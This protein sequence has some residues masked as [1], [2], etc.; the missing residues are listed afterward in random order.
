MEIILLIYLN[1][2]FYYSSK[3]V[4]NA[5]LYEQD[6]KMIDLFD[7]K[8][9]IKKILE[10][11]NFFNYYEFFC[12]TSQI[13]NTLHESINSFEF[14]FFKKYKYVFVDFKDIQPIYNLFDFN[15]YD[16]N[17]KTKK[18][19]LINHIEYTGRFFRDL[20]YDI[21]LGYENKLFTKSNNINQ[22]DFRFIRKF[23]TYINCKYKIE[24]KKFIDILDYY[25]N[26]YGPE[27]EKCTFISHEIPIKKSNE[28]ESI[29]KYIIV[30]EYTFTVFNHFYNID[31]DGL[32]NRFKYNLLI[33]E[34]PNIRFKE[35][36]SIEN[37]FENS[38]VIEDK[39]DEKLFISNLNN[40]PIKLNKITFFKHSNIL[41]ISHKKNGKIQ[42][43]LL[44]K[45]FYKEKGYINSN[46]DKINNTYCRYIVSDSNEL[47]KENIINNNINIRAIC[48]NKNTD[49]IKEIKI[50]DKRKIILSKNFSYK[51]DDSIYNIYQ[52]KRNTMLIRTDNFKIYGNIKNIVETHILKRKNSEF[53]KLLF[54]HKYNDIIGCYNKRINLWTKNLSISQFRLIIYPE[55]YDLLSRLSE[56]KDEYAHIQN[57]LGLNEFLNNIY[58][59]RLNMYFVG[60]NN[61]SNGKSENIKLIFWK[62]EFIKIYQVLI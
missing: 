49:I 4:I 9:D 51:F 19:I 1:L 50:N 21:N 53:I 60:I 28:K 59:K 31:S 57:N 33:I 18:E 58:I 34:D 26:I 42:R 17:E 16:K 8:I 32:I 48:A 35:I 29:L 6:K 25:K 24:D 46:L 47:N 45:C 2:K 15:K 12:A 10:K 22:I 55:V 3:E 27:A 62:K 13:A 11:K 44:E 14:E 23:L 41:L 43:I 36:L 38:N 40:N 5:Y 30:R 56:N 52:M 39:S 54:D 61:Y 20:T 7:F 37:V